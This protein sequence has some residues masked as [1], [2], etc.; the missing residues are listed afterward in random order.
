[1]LTIL[2]A[3]TFFLQVGDPKRAI[4]GFDDGIRGMQAG[5]TRRIVVPPKVISEHIPCIDK[6]GV[7]WRETIL[8]FKWH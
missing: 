3:I 6:Q 7:T 4:T 2:P 8:G 5:G 1:M